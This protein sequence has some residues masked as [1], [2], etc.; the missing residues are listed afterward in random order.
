MALR[1]RRINIFLELWCL[2]AKRGL[3]IWVSSTSFQKSN[4]GWPQQPLT[5]KVL[6]F[7][8]IFHDSTKTIFFQNIKVKLNLRTM[9]DS[10]VLSIDFPDLKTSAASMTSTASTTSVAS[11][12]FTASFHQKKLLIQMIDSS[13]A[14]IHFPSSWSQSPHHLTNPISSKKFLIMIV[15]SSLAPKWPIL[16][17]FCG[18]D[19]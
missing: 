12:T 11:M 17:P 14:V 9:D 7:N 3:D 8:M 15:W 13:L 10:E 16:V 4:I 19:H 1:G 6:N 5:E 2:L 18:V